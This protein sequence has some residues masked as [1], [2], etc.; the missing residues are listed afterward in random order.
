MT[1]NII[2]ASFGSTRKIT[3]DP[4]NYQYDIVQILQIEGLELPEYYEVDFCNVGDDSTITMV[5]SSSGVRIPDNYLQNGK[6]IKAYIVLNG[7]D[8]SVQTRYEITIPVNLRPERSDIEP[9]PAEQ[10]T[11]DSL[12]EAMNTAVEQT[13]ADVVATGEKADAAAQSAENA[14]AA[15]QAVQSMSVSADTL[16]AGSAATVEKTVDPNTGAVNLEFGIPTGATG[17]QGETGNG[18]QS[19][20]LHGQSGL[21]KTYRITFTDSTTF[22]FTV[23]DGNGIQSVVLHS[24][25]GLNKVYRITFINGDTFDFTVADGNGIQ[26]AILNADYTLTLT[27]QD[28][29]SYTSPPIRGATGATGATGNGI[30][31]IVKTGTS[32]N[33]DTYTITYTNGTTF[34]YT[35]T[36][37]NVSSVAGKTGAVTLDA[38]DVGYDDAETYSSGTVGAELTQLNQHLNDLEDTLPTEDTGQGLLEEEFRETELLGVILDIFSDLPSDEI[39]NDIADELNTENEWLEVLEHEVAAFVEGVA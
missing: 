15:S 20:T 36:N 3:T 8:E 6:N 2:T 14:A 30:Q 16:P 33:V 4:V 34:T 1:Y 11:I 38:D 19:I 32:G 26:S 13:A 17:A 10:S 21:E 25:S 39:L 23:T 9:T 24:Q 18:I 5:G 37:G 28:G 29:T 31:S 22:D 27:F 12:I 35:V 7:D